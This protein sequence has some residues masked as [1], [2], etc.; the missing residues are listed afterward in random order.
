MKKLNRNE[1]VINRG[2]P[3]QKIQINAVFCSLFFLHDA[4]RLGF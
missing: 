2:V 3:A 1:D 4:C